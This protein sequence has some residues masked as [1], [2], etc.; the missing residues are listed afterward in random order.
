MES[1]AG[2]ETDSSLAQSARKRDNP[3]NSLPK[4]DY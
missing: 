2:P 3:K 1:G 4:T